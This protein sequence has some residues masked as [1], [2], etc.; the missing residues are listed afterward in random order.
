MECAILFIVFVV[1]L[2]F[3]VPIA[4]CLVAAGAL[5]GIS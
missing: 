3:G 5:G 1:L 4:L 2:V